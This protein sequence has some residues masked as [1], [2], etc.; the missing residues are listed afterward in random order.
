MGSY[1]IY[2]QTQHSPYVF[3]AWTDSN[4]NISEDQIRPVKVLYFVSHKL[5]ISH[6]YDEHIFALVA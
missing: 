3:T 5:K 1:R 4:S 6:K 2:P